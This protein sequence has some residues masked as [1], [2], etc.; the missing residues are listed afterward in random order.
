[1]PK[2]KEQKRKEAEARDQ[3]RQTLLARLGLPHYYKST[4]QLRQMCG[5]FRVIQVP[6]E[7]Q[8]LMD[9]HFSEPLR[10]HVSGDF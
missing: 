7:V 9:R 2:S 3:E 10:V 5:G 4:E 8:Q 1:M 6:N